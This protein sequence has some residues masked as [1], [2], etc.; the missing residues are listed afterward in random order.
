[1][2]PGLGATAV[3]LAAVVAVLIFG[4]LGV[5]HG[6]TMRLYVATNRGG[7]IIPGTRVWLDGV[8]VGAVRWIRFQP[9]GVDTTRRLL[10]ALD[11]KE[12]VRSHIR[13]NTRVG[14][15]PGTGQLGAPVVQLS[16][17]DPFSPP[18]GEG[19]TLISG[20]SH[21][22]REAREQI[23]IAAQSLPIVV[24][25]IEAV[26]DQ[27]VSRTGTIGA[28][29]SE[30][31]NRSLRILRGDADRLMRNTA[32]QGGT[33]AL[34]FSEGFGARVRGA[35][36][37][38]DSLL[39]RATATSGGNLHGGPADLTHSIS[40]VDSELSTLS[41]QLQYMRGPTATDSTEM[42]SLQDQISESRDRLHALVADIAHHPLRY[43]NF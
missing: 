36:K 22:L 9:P 35:V 15:R 19:D 34:M 13:R 18:I 31:D 41:T 11:V 27:V 28:L 30:E 37:Q 16:G 7:G 2:L 29:G 43:M 1:M 24:S 32:D 12:S 21:Q 14:L 26:R 39:R 10:I 20:G 25:N 33:I 42:T 4:R 8:Q 5:V 23:G 3:V 38:A 17:T 40:Q 6:R